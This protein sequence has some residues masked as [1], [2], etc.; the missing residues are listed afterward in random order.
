MVLTSKKTNFKIED[1]KLY[2]SLKQ[3]QKELQSRSDSEWFDWIYSRMEFDKNS[4]S[5]FDTK[6]YSTYNDLLNFYFVVN[7][8][9][10]SIDIILKEDR[11]VIKDDLNNSLLTKMVD[12]ETLPSVDSDTIFSK[13]LVFYNIKGYHI[14]TLDERQRITK[15]RITYNG[16]TIKLKKGFLINSTY[17]IQNLV[18]ETNSL[19]KISY[20]KESYIISKTIFPDELFEDLFMVLASDLEIN[21]NPSNVYLEKVKDSFIKY[22]NITNFEKLCWLSCELKSHLLSDDNSD[23]QELL[24]NFNIEADRLLNDPLSKDKN[25]KDDS[26][27]FLSFLLKNYCNIIEINSYGKKVGTKMFS[28]HI[29]GPVGSSHFGIFTIE[30]IPK[31]KNEEELLSVSE[32]KQIFLNHLKLYEAEFNSVL[33]RYHLKFLQWMIKEY[34]RG[35]IP[36]ISISITFKTGKTVSFISGFT[37]K[38]VKIIPPLTWLLKSNSR[39]LYSYISELNNIQFNSRATSGRAP[40]G[41]FF[42]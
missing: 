25:L 7:N 16:K 20:N 11:G 34:E 36:S 33:N 38:L 29:N 21:L 27:Y 35:T 30:D 12:R 13:G 9:E 41:V 31:S 42:R 39:F 32:Q 5:F 10:S 37:Y 18:E 26:G 19:R 3:L 8:I 22:E 17:E 15:Q 6:S 28:K 24:K 4:G 40:R 1:T 2:K 14:S 23:K